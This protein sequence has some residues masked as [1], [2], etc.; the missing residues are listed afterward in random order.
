MNGK[1]AKRQRAEVQAVLGIESIPKPTKYQFSNPRYV[2]VF[3]PELGEEVDELYTCTLRMH[4]S[5]PR[6]VLKM[7]RKVLKQEKK[8]GR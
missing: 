3:D 1:Q 5:E 6:A 8:R 2:T 4:P 7:Y